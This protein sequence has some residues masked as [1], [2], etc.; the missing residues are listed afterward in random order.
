MLRTLKTVVSYLI[1]GRRCTH[2]EKGKDEK[3]E[4]ADP[5]HRVVLEFSDVRRSGVEGCKCVSFSADDREG[6]WLWIE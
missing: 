2:S 4:E 1:T 6:L 5:L 3:G